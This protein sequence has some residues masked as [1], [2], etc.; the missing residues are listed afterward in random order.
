MGR[1]KNINEIVDFTKFLTILSIFAIPFLVALEIIIAN[2]SSKFDNNV[3]FIVL[4]LL[5]LFVVIFLLG[6]VILLKNKKIFNKRKMFKKLG[7][8]FIF[9]AYILEITG[10][11]GLIYYNDEFKNW[12]VTN[13]ISSINH[14]HLA[15]SIY[16][17]SIIDK[18][19]ENTKNFVNL[20]KDII[21]FGDIKYSDTVYS[22]KYEKEILEREEGAIY[23]IINISGITIGRDYHYEGYM[24][25]IYDPSKVKVAKSSGAGTFEGAFGETLQTIAR[26]ND[27]LVAINAGGF[28]DPNWNSNGGIPHGDVIINGVIDSSYNRGDEGGGLIGFDK[29]NRLVLKKMTGE[30]ALNMGIRDAVDWGPFLITNGVNHFRNVN[31]YTWAC[32]RTAI[33]QRED[34][35]VLMVVIDGLQE[36][37]K[38]VSYA[39]M[40]KIMENY[41]AVNAANLDG[42]TS[43]AMVEGGK[44]I[45]SPWNG[46][47][48]TYR[49]LPNAFI[50]TK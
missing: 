39:D 35:I 45:N 8:F 49:W 25:V 3:K 14:K 17:N 33:G 42:G 47:V 15:T 41:G 19:V 44:Y 37:S 36:H 50:V 24:A 22:N 20:D 1:V 23:K 26:K 34:G 2:N 21:N 28:Y 16:D 4:F 5:I 31:Y 40:A 7:L 32:A 27:A 48:K 10:I 9:T 30:E 11:I 13:S 12:F 6:I 46:Y 18:V 43:T 38:G 29:N